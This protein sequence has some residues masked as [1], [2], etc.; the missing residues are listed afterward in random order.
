MSDA[1]DNLAKS[2]VLNRVP[3][4]WEKKAYPSK[5]L[6]A[7]WFDDL[8]LRI[9]QLSDW[10]KEEKIDIPRSIWVSGL[11]N[12]MSFLTAIMQVT[13]RAKGLPLDDV[14]LFL[15]KKDLVL[16][17]LNRWSYKLTLP[18][19]MTKRNYQ[20]MLRMDSL[21]MVCF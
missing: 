15:F 16:K 17:F 2:L 3:G 14:R 7:N 10:T 8:I 18:V 1:M 19:L 9:D 6:L 12:P 11:F 21:F 20:D 5:K 13:A 4:N